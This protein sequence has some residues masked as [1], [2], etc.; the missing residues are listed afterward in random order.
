MGIRNWLERKKKEAE[1]KLYLPEKR[2]LLAWAEKIIEPGEAVLINLE[3]KEVLVH[4]EK[5]WKRVPQHQ[6]SVFPSKADS[7][8]ADNFR[9][10][11]PPRLVMCL[12]GRF[13]DALR[14][15]KRAEQAK[16]WQK[17]FGSGRAEVWEWR[18]YFEARG[19]PL[20]LRFGFS[21]EEKSR[22][23]RY[24]RA[25]AL[26]NL[27][28]AERPKEDFPERFSEKVFLG[29]AVWIGGALRSSVIIKDT[30]L[31]AALEQ[32]ALELPFDPRF[33]PIQS[34]ELRVGRIEITIMQE[35]RLPL[36]QKSL[37]GRIDPTKGYQISWN[38]RKRGWY[39]PEVFNCAR[40][41]GM[42]DLM[43]RLAEDKAGVS[44][45]H[46][47]GAQKETFEV[48][49]WIE[50]PDRER[51]LD[52]AGPVAKG[53][54]YQDFNSAFQASLAA[55]LGR[56]AE[57]LLRIQE[58]DGNIPPVINPL[59]GKSK[60]IDWVRQALA[61]GALV[62]ADQTLNREAYR[63][64]GE[65]AIGYM[66]RN[67]FSHPLLSPATK[68]IASVY[69]AKTLLLLDRREEVRNL[70]E[71]IT[72]N[73]D[74]LS[75]AP[76][77]HLQAASLLVALG[78][79]QKE[80]FSKGKEILAVAIE[81]YQARLKRGEK[82]QLAFFPEA[83]SIFLKLADEG[84]SGCQE[85]A[86]AMIEWLVRQQLSDG[87]FPI[88]P[89]SAFAYTRGTGK[90]FEI[91]TLRPE[92]NRKPILKVWRWLQEMQYTEENA[93]FMDPAIRGKV[94]GGFRHD[95]LNSEVWSD[96]AAHVLVGG[97]RLS[98]WLKTG[99]ESRMF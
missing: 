32:A 9:K 88:V 31:D 4:G 70:A 30:A 79:G 77:S 62:L 47:K 10:R 71:A 45:H 18:E 73:L 58:P 17:I 57:S 63:E 51:V 72:R 5:G 21:L 95:A 39:L 97:A 12:P 3:K 82:M 85:K 92:E 54:S 36:S 84:E 67:L 19:R 48:E 99:K 46:L 76:I 23:T 87:S 49:D 1:D 91:L 14:Y 90:I 86:Q 6:F 16:G 40:F 43:T 69:Y 20:P 38:G 81:D 66:K 8:W 52:L 35:P 61:A 41:S 27:E 94:L 89:G 98:A 26:Q 34:A 68:T 25:R 37:E 15:L 74:Q 64:G 80:S 42:P 65:K 50:S 96:A 53:A 60:Q 78:P 93:Y 13:H 44:A 29:A 7:P 59:T 33:K 56:A 22:M 83:I 28:K 11:D 2:A 55:T 75:Y 24:V